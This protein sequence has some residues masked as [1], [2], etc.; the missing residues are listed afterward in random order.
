MV[1][2]HFI[3]KKLIQQLISYHLQSV[4]KYFDGCLTMTGFFGHVVSIT[5]YEE[6]ILFPYIKV[7][8]SVEIQ[9]E[10]VDF[11]LE[12]A[13]RDIFRKS[14]EIFLQMSLTQAFRGE[15]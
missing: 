7:S 10:R 1:L 2:N 13:D 14:V 8:S 15:G 11:I 5:N 6:L 4:T 3:P 12:G 9:T